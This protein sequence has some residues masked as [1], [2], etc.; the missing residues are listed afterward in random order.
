MCQPNALERYFIKSRYSG[1]LIGI[2]NSAN[3]QGDRLYQWNDLQNQLCQNQWHFVPV[4]SQEKD[5]IY[6]IQSIYNRKVFDISGGNVSNDNQILQWDM[7]M[8]DINQQFRLI[9]DANQKSCSIQS[10]ATGNILDTKTKEFITQTDFAMYAN[11]STIDRRRA[12][13]ELIPFN[14]GKS[15]SNSS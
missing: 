11:E 13:W 10:L 2:T 12:L 5:R 8:N 7:G 15:S 6:M 1:K 4:T 14:T 9:A 3:N